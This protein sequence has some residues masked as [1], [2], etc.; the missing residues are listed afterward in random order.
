MFTWWNDSKD[1]GAF[2]NGNLHG[3]N[4]P[5][6]ITNYLYLL[7]AAQNAINLAKNKHP[8]A[9]DKIIRQQFSPKHCQSLF[10]DMYVAVDPLKG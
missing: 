8:T 5:N 4:L 2:Q 6:Y 9:P 10:T 1:D 3:F 7:R